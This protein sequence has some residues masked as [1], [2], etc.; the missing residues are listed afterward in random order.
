MVKRILCPLRRVVMLEVSSHRAH[1][2]IATTSSFSPSDVL[3]LGLYTYTPP[4]I[5]ASY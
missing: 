1:R 3:G 5:Y 4:I 2:A